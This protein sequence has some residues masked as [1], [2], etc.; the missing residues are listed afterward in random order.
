MKRIWNIMTVFS[1]I[2][3]KINIVKA[4]ENLTLVFVKFI[5]LKSG[6]ITFKHIC[7]HEVDIF[8]HTGF[9]KQVS[10]ILTFLLNYLN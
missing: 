4:R 3:F 5:W 10:F 6:Q 7:I 2:L 8:K 1:T 9:K